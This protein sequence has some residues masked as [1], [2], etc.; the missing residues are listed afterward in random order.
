MNVPYVKNVT[1]FRLAGECENCNDSMLLYNCRGCSNCFGCTNLRNKRHYIFNRPYPKEEYFKKIKDFNYSSFADFQKLKV[2]FEDIYRDTLRKFAI[3]YKAV[4]CVGDN[5]RNAKNCKYCFDILDDVEDCKYIIWS[6]YKFKDGYD[7][8][9]VGGATELDY[10][11]V[12]L[13]SSRTMGSLVTWGS[14]DIFYSYN[15]HSSSHLFGC[16]GL[17]NKE[18]CILNKQYAK[19]EYEELVPKIIEHM[20]KQPYVDKQGRIYKYGEFFPPELSPFAYNETIA[21]EYFPL[22]KEQ[23][24]KA[25]YRWK[26]PEP[27][28]YE[29]HL[30][31]EDL[32]DH[33]KDVGDDI[34]NK[35]IQCLHNQTCNEQC[36]QAFKIIPE[37]LA[38]YR[39]LNL[40]L[41]RLC[42][43]CRHYQRLKQRNPLKLWHRKCQCAGQKSENNIYANTITHQHGHN[44]CPNEFE[45]SYSPDRKEIVYC[46]QCYNAEV[47]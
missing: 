6:G 35:N 18:Y 1:I 22:T 34:L 26:D 23:A 20:N 28:T 15:C 8:F 10:E 7:S 27:R 38:F 30:K 44:P 17:R 33:I 36:T 19:E 12:D 24:E 4:D 16:I 25:G 39:R 5:I 31:P 40:P 37:E 41:P 42:P 29:I 43:N 21:Q 11:S 2:N 32:P 3:F 13:T 45:T 46:E 47:V 14:Y 9:G